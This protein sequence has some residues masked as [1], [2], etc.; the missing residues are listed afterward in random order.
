M[1]GPDPGPRSRHS[2]ATD[3][4]E[5][6]GIRLLIPLLGPWTRDSRR[7]MDPTE[8]FAS[9][10]HQPHGSL[11]HRP[12]IRFSCSETRGPGSVSNRSF[13][14][15]NP[16]EL[17]SGKRLHALERRAC[18]GPFLVSAPRPRDDGRSSGQRTRHSQPSSTG[19][20]PSAAS[21]LKVS[22][23]SGQRTR[24]G[25]IDFVL[26]R[27]TI[28]EVSR[29]L[30]SSPILRGRRPAG[31]AVDHQRGLPTSRFVAERRGLS[32]MKG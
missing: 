19:G 10:S 31:C 1:R 26:T 5:C 4:S 9:D 11:A 25:Q 12:M 30:D 13:E 32:T 17:S 21:P 18:G 2:H 20:Q 23:S 15:Y 16:G 29:L 28:N 27:S 24:R 3:P 14:L 22:S 8:R 6:F 7:R